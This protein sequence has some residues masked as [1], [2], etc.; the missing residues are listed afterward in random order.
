MSNEKCEV[1]KFNLIRLKMKL[2]EYL[3]IMP[4][5]LP[6]GCTTHMQLVVE[7]VPKIKKNVMLH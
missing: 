5:V 1:N 4:F 2:Y 7:L 3:F 6:S